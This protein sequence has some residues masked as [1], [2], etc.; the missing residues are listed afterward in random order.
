[1]DRETGR[2]KGFAFVEMAEEEAAQTAIS[3]F[4]GAEVGGRTIKVAEAK[5][6]PTRGNY[7]HR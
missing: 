4:N 2:S 5:P 1:M 7:D 3:Q 6:R